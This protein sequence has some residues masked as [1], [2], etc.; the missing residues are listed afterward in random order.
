MG[1]PLD[2]YKPF[3][4]ISDSMTKRFPSTMVCASEPMQTCHSPISTRHF[5]DTSSQCDTASGL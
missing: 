4:S 1:L 5:R 2:F 3:H